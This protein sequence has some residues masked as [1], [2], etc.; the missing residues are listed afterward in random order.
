MPAIRRAASEGAAISSSSDFRAL[1]HNAFLKKTAATGL[2]SF[3]SSCTGRRHPPGYV[4]VPIDCIWRP[5]RPISLLQASNVHTVQLSLVSAASQQTALV[6]VE[7]VFTGTNGLL[8]YRNYPAHGSRKLPPST[9]LTILERDPAT[10]DLNSASY[11]IR[12]RRNGEAKVADPLAILSPYIDY[13]HADRFGFVSCAFV[14]Y[15]PVFI[16]N[17]EGGEDT[18]DGYTEELRC[19]NSTMLGPTLP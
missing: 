16:E 8:E 9:Y 10:D 17:V 6:V 14:R 15:R 4:S 18:L 1:K 11:R 7:D 12:E 2:Q 19:Y 5:G 13:I 3:H